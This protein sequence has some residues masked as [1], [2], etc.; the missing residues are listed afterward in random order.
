[1]IVIQTEILELAASLR[2][3]SF[4]LE[5]DS[6]TPKWLFNLLRFAF[7]YLYLTSFEALCCEKFGH[8]LIREAVL[9]GNIVNE[10]NHAL[11]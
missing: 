8:R 6:A 5:L 4:I 11:Q 2:A 7:D 10:G 9:F 3:L 1:L